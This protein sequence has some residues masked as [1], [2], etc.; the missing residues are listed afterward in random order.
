MSKS[1]SISIFGSH[2]FVH[3]KKCSPSLSLG[4]GGALGLSIDDIWP[5]MAH[6]A[7]RVPGSD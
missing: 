4:C 3:V 5:L 7:T 6:L 2:I 1:L